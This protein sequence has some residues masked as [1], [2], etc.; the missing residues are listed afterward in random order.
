MQFN[1]ETTDKP[2]TGTALDASCPSQSRRNMED[3]SASSMF[4]ASAGDRNDSAA[5]VYLRPLFHGNRLTKVDTQPAISR[6]MNIGIAGFKN[7]MTHFIFRLRP[8]Y[9]VRTIKEA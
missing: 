9:P 2:Q 7:Q 6:Q 5:P 3:A 4:T 8:V 1:M